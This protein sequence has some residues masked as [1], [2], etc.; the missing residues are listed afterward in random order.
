V[1][2]FAVFMTFANAY[3]AELTAQ[4]GRALAPAITVG[5][6]IGRGGFA[7]VYAGVDTAL[8]RD[9]A[10]KVLR[11]ELA[12]DEVMRARFRREA[13]AVARLR[14]PHIV[15]IYSVGEQDGIVWYVMPLL[16]GPSLKVHLERSGRLAIPDVRRVIDET[17][18][19]L[20]TA[21]RA[22]IVH[23][24]IKP[25]NMLLD[26]PPS[27]PR[28]LV[29]DFGIAKA[30]SGTM[31]S[32]TLTQTGIVIGT[33]HYMS[34]EQAAGEPT[35]A[36]SDIYSL[37]VVAYQLL[38]GELPF[39]APTVAALLV[40]QLQDEAPSVLR[41]RPDCPS[42]L[43]AA[44]AR[45]LAKDPAQRWQSADD[46][47]SA[48]AASAMQTMA[49]R[50]S[51]GTRTAVVVSPIQSFRT[52]VFVSLGLIGALAVVDAARG[53]LLL[54][55]LGALV[56]AFVW[57]VQYGRL[58]TAGYEW[59]DLWRSGATGS[60]S[61][62]PLDSAEFG[63]HEGAI[64]QARAERAAIRVQ[65]EK[66]PRATRP[67]FERAVRAADGLL[68]QAS[69][70]GRQLYGLERQ[71]E[72]GP[73]EIERRLAATE[74][75]PSSPGRAQRLAVLERRR[76]AVHAL[77]RRRDAL[78]ATLTT[79]LTA[80]ARLRA[81]IEQEPDRLDDALRVATGCLESAQPT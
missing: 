61:P 12:V 57:A 9:V 73:E 26:G 60:S 45:C 50:R 70:L 3:D 27:R 6:P 22:G 20:A 72:P 63:P 19:A 33:P 25:D 54:A 34:P 49:A 13:E 59:R 53:Q 52:T 75:E 36:R 42:D 46:L 4:L 71:I 41:R 15:P 40:K 51:S 29:T 2:S 23:R 44:I 21:H 62:V 16:S 31:D 37:G 66:M 32:R 58:W 38:T 64:Q 69:A 48:V 79:T 80:L 17:A 78:A 81:A 1:L 67:R 24:D 55:P 43:A 68:G 14:H 77:A 35:D 5:A 10:V 8:K 76:D 30:L 74:S 47:R 11:P 7:L 39:E 28:V 65:F 18:D 56:A